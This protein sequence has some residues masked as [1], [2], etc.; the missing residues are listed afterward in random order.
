MAA[1]TIQREVYRL[2]AELGE[3]IF[4]GNAFAAALGEPGLAFTKTAA[5]FLGDGFVG[6]VVNHDL[7]QLNDGREFAGPSCPSS[8]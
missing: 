6:V 5:I 2:H 1:L 4:H 3:H 7:Q 8:S